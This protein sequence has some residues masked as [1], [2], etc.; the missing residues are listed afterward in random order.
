MCQTCAVSE[1]NHAEIA[2]IKYLTEIFKQL[3]AHF[4][5][6]LSDYPR[7]MRVGLIVGFGEI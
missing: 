4:R 2:K 6:V 7:Q 3:P 1:Y 5:F